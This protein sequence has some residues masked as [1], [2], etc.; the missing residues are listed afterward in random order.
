MKRCGVSEIK[1][2]HQEARV[3]GK[4]ST[5]ERK[6]QSATRGTSPG[7]S[8]WL[9]RKAAENTGDV[10]PHANLEHMRKRAK[11]TM[12]SMA[13]VFKIELRVDLS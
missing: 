1:M 4:A 12:T 13:T 6:T 11:Q 2:S 9:S 7:C 5:V 10:R 3:D 8:H